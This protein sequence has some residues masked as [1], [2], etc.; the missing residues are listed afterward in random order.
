MR[1]RIESSKSNNIKNVKARTVFQSE[2]ESR[3]ELSFPL[4]QINCS[5]SMQRKK[6]GNHSQLLDHD[7]DHDDPRVG[8]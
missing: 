8:N 3:A 4:P 5:K 7:H 6:H 1:R 2:S